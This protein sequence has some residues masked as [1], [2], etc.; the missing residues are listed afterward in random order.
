MQIGDGFLPITHHH[1]GVDQPGLAKSPAHQKN[2]VFVILG[3]KNRHVTF[4]SN[5]HRG[6]Q[7]EWPC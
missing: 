7:C 4:H 6:F 2:I 5:W 1:Q 3:Q